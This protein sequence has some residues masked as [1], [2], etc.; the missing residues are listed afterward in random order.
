[1]VQKIAQKIEK[2]GNDS[3]MVEFTAQSYFND[4]PILGILR[5]VMKENFCAKV[6]R[7]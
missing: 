7:F 2:N 1:M 6:N 4:P 3:E 5:G